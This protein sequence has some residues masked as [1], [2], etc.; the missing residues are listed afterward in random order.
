MA[1]PQL[2]QPRHQQ[3]QNHRASMGMQLQ[4]VF[5][6]EASRRLKQQGQ[7]FINDLAMGI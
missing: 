5:A 4:Y 2:N 1:S 6:S 3:I 7:A